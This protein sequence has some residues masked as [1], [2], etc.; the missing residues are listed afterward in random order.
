M[1]VKRD[2]SHK[3]RERALACTAFCPAK[4]DPHTWKETY[5]RQKRRRSVKSV[6]TWAFARTAFS[7]QN[8]RMHVKRDICMSKETKVRCVGKNVPTH[9]CTIC[10]DIWNAD[11]FSMYICVSLAEIIWKLDSFSTYMCVPKDIWNA[12]SISA[13]KCVPHGENVWNSD[14]SSTY[15]C[16]SYR[17]SYTMQTLAP[18]TCVSHMKR[19]MKC[20]LFLNIHTCVSR[21]IWKICQRALWKRLYSAKE[22]Q[23]Y[24]M[25][26]LSPHTCVSHIKRHERHT[27]SPHTNVST[28]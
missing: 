25:P 28:L 12:D 17:K 11:S 3:C 16:L 9:V 4:R 20:R 2:L 22:I 10:E 26:T 21:K 5:A 23:T 1:H 19:Y 8:R 7:C 6:V 27:L 14:S 15:N 18:H 13:Y 24:E